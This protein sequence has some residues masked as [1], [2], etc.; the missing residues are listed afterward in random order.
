MVLQDVSNLLSPSLQANTSLDTRMKT[1]TLAGPSTSALG[2]STIALT[3]RTAPLALARMKLKDTKQERRVSP[4]LRKLSGI[5]VDTD[6]EIDSRRPAAIGSIETEISFSLDQGLTRADVLVNAEECKDEAKR[7]SAELERLAT[8]YSQAVPE[9]A[10]LRNQLGVAHVSGASTDTHTKQVCL[11]VRIT[12]IQSEV[13]HHEAELLVLREGLDC[14]A[15]RI[16]ELETDLA[17]AF[18][19]KEFHEAEIK[20]MRKTLQELEAGKAERESMIAQLTDQVKHLSERL[21]ETSEEAES[22][23]GELKDAQLRQ[24][25]Q[26]E[27]GRNLIAAQ[28]ELE[29]AYDDAVAQLEL[30]KREHGLLSYTEEE[31]TGNDIDNSIEEETEDDDAEHPCT[32]GSETLIDHRQMGSQQNNSGTQEVN[33]VH[34]HPAEDVTEEFDLVNVETD[35]TPPIPPAPSSSRS[36][37]RNTFKSRLNKLVASESTLRAKPSRPPPHALR[38]FAEKELEDE[39]ADLRSQVETSAV[40]SV[41]DELTDLCRQFYSIDMAKVSRL[42][43]VQGQIDERLSA[44]RLAATKLK[45]VQSFEA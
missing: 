9:I 13:A 28:E 41:S 34:L 6:T 3:D 21:T 11:N 16:I 31:Q 25:L 23:R 40:P 37:G 14:H 44:I 7:T 42:H 29:H 36:G 15:L 26:D 5:D 1:G 17:S 12:S 38:L 8:E 18:A 39:L 33:E 30:W 35:L 27:E 43:S 32:D 20:T 2:P 10:H 19:S 24:Q 45:A 4:R 22:L